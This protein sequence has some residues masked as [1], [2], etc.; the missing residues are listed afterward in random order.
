M[1]LPT[2]MQFDTAEAA[3]MVANT[4][5]YLARRLQADEAVRALNLVWS[6]DQIAAE[7][8]ASVSRA[9]QTLRELVT[10]YVC[11]AALSLRD[12]IT[13]LKEQTSASP[14]TAYRWLEQ[15]RQIF[16]ETYRPVT[17]QA[18]KVPRPGHP[19]LTSYSSAPLTRVVV[20]A[21]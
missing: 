4:P 3:Y 9:P 8:R 19:N 11:L 18:F 1:T 14:L 6:A 12:D 21:S 13:A 10:P 7:Y 16:I 15:I 5:L 2:T 17:R 20:P